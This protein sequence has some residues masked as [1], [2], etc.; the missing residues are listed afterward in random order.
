MVPEWMARVV[1]I[2]RLARVSAAF[3]A[4]SNVWFV[5]LWSRAHEEEARPGLLWESPLLLL[6]VGGAGTAVGLYSFGATLN[7]LLDVSRDRALH[8]SRPLVS[9]RVSVEA[10]SVSVAATLILAVLG[11]TVFGTRGVVLT[12]LLSLAILVFNVA[13]RFV[14]A[15]GLV[16]L[17]L[18][19][20]AH[21]LVPN[22]G[23]RFVWPVWVI[24]THA[25]SVG[26]ASHAIGRKVP[27]I[28][29]RAVIAAGLG[30]I[31]ASAVLLWVGSERSG[32]DGGLWPGWVD[33]WV[34]AL[35][36]GLAA[37]FAIF[38]WRRVRELGPGP[39]SAEKVARYGALWMPLYGIAWLAGEGLW[40]QAAVLGGL[41]GA[42]VLG[43]TL[44]REVYAVI[45]RPMAFKR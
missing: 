8:R 45:E 41:A 32:V 22:L 25:L 15:V 16:L 3:A 31:G 1:S 28:S 34:A 14:P 13:G 19:Y 39:R 7:D 10:A 29:Q 21:S 4:V 27:P 26:W 44:L 6:L 20:A 5:I 38:A 30:W 24:M 18:I 33:P 40:V 35:P 12:V 23:L 36:A 2:L 11:S 43:L 42:A 37:A 17:A 9:G